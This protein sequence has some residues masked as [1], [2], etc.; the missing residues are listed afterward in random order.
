MLKHML[1]KTLGHKTLLLLRL[2]SSSR[3]K[4][5]LVRGSRKKARR[6]SM[7]RW[8]VLVHAA[9]HLGRSQITGMNSIQTGIMP[10]ETF[11]TVPLH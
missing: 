11:R 2:L 1:Y 7:L 8:G 10:C 3:L 6:R 9:K 5:H 4:A